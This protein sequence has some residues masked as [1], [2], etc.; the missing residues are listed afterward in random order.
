[1]NSKF[2]YKNATV[3]E[4]S[5]HFLTVTRQA[6]W[7]VKKYYKDD[8]STLEKILQAEVAAKHNLKIVKLQLKIDAMKVG[9][10]C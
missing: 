10:E 9:Y 7:L 3:Q 4:I 8:S 5:T 1:M 2:N 6:V